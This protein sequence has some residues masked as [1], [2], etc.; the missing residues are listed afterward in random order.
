MREAGWPTSTKNPA[1]IHAEQNSKDRCIVEP[2]DVTIDHVAVAKDEL[3]DLKLFRRNLAA[4][5]NDLTSD[6]NISAAVA[7]V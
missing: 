7:R 1:V 3:F 5:L 6:R 4:I 2:N